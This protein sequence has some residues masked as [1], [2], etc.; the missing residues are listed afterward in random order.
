[1]L[2]V[3]AA[4]AFQLH[5]FGP[6]PTPALSLCFRGGGAGPERAP[7][8]GR[9]GLGGH[10]AAAHGPAGRA[11]R[12]GQ[13]PGSRHGQRVR[14]S[15]GQ[16]CPE[17]LPG[18]SPGQAGRPGGSG[19]PRRL[20][21][22]QH[23]PAAGAAAQQLLPAAP[24]EERG[25]GHAAPSEENVQLQ[26]DPGD[27]KKSGPRQQNPESQ[28]AAEAVADRE[29]LREAPAGAAAQVPAAGRGVHAGLPGSQA[30]Q[31]GAGEQGA[32]QQPPAPGAGHHHGRHRSR[33]AEREPEPRA[34][35]RLEEEEVAAGGTGQEETQVFA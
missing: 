15:I 4:V 3:D 17:P 21:R 35:Q 18:E 26:Q 14:P 16:S 34:P 11:A 30:G 27:K 1:M 25:G 7:G 9:R 32:E 24:Q 10:P 23:L 5:I 31:P 20:L 12:A 19:H 8:P 13:D 22:R 29:Q 28:K 33:G 6:S 2:S